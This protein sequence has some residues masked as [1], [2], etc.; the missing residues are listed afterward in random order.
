M[1]NAAD[2]AAWKESY[3]PRLVAKLRTPKSPERL[4][5]TRDWT[6]TL[7]REGM[8]TRDDLHKSG[9]HPDE[10]RLYDRRDVTP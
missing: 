6:R 9:I 3:L 8:L 5:S 10:L 7:L 2:L 4:E 1:S